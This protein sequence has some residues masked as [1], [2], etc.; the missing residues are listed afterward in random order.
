M[1]ANV[2][3]PISSMA[4]FHHPIDVDRLQSVPMRDGIVLYAD[5]YRPRQR[6]RPLPVLLMR[7][8]Y[9][10]EIA[11]TVVYAHPSW[12]AAQGYIVVIQE[13]RGCGRSQGVFEPFRHEVEDGIDTVQWCR[14]LPGSSGK[15]GM[16]GFSYQG[17]TQFQ[18]AAWPKTET[19]LTALCPAMAGVQF[20]DGWYYWGGALAL[21]FVLPW[22]IQLAQDSAQFQQLEPQATELGRARFQIQQWLHFTPL[23]ELELLQNQPVG[24]FYFDWV[25]ATTSDA[26]YHHTLAPQTQLDCL[27]TFDFP[28][29]HVSGWADPFLVATLHAYRYCC[30]KSSQ[31]QKLVIGPWQHIPWSRQ[32]GDVDFGPEAAPNIDRLQIRWFDCWLKDK[33]NGVDTEAPVQAFEMG[34]NRW[35][36]LPDW[37]P[38]IQMQSLWLSSDGLACGPDSCGRLDLQPAEAANETVISRTQASATQIAESF[39]FDTYVYDPRIATPATPYGPYDQRAVHRRPDLLLYT[40]APLK[41]DWA[42]A[43][44]P[45]FHLFAATTAVDTDW[46]VK[47]MQVDPN[48]QSLL[49]TAGVL[50]ARFRNSFTQ[51]IPVIPDEIIEYDIV[52]RPTC[53][54]VYAGTCLQVA[55]SSGAFPWIDRNPNTDRWPAS[56]RFSDFQTAVQTVFHSVECPSRLELPLREIS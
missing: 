47:L 4:A 45:T 2:L 32:V 15:V 38:A 48:G 11:S 26:D 3:V 40:S 46:V 50:R 34:S 25:T 6:D 37:P 29:L 31:L 1:K 9:G 33:P 18:A 17:V 28:A 27:D 51:P 22:A 53:R 35:L 56:V 52:L 10:R 8:P 20:Y 39:A 14:D 7:L 12:Y 43:G 49:L 41:Q 36:D 5:I 23:Q 13:V 55:I 30:S 16:Y 24:Q 42:I 44:S 21:D 19:G 54:L